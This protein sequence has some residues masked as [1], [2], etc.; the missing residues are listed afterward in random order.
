MKAKFLKMAKCKNGAELMKKYPTEEAFFAAFPE[1]LKMVKAQNGTRVDT[2]GNGIPDEYESIGSSPINGQPSGQFSLGN[3]P[4]APQNIPNS[5]GYAQTQPFANQPN[6]PMPT[7]ASDMFMKN[8]AQTNQQFGVPEALPADIGFKSS[9]PEASNSFSDKIAPYIGSA[10]DIVKGIA[11]LSGQKK[12]K[13]RVRQARKVSDVQKWASNTR[14]EAPERRYDT[15]WDRMVE[16][17]ERFPTYGVGSNVLTRNGGNIP[18]AQ[19][20]FSQI[21]NN[22]KFG[23]FMQEQGV[24][25]AFGSIQGALSNNSAEGQIGKGLGTAAGTVFG[26]PVGG[27]IGGMAGELIGG[28]FNTSQG[29]IKRDK[30]AI[31]RNQD[32]IMGNAMGMGIQNQYNA[33][34]KDGGDIPGYAMGGEIQTNEHGDIEE[35]AYNPITASNGGSGILGITKAAS[36]AK[37]DSTGKL[38]IGNYNGSEFNFEGNETIVETGDGGNLNMQETPQTKAEILGNLYLG[39][40]AKEAFADI[41]ENILKKI[42]KGRNIE[43]MKFKQLGNNIATV[44]KKVN[45]LNKYI[46]EFGANPNPTKLEESTA[47][48]KKIAQDMYYP[49]LDKAMNTAAALQSAYNDAAKEFGYKDSAKFLKDL[50]KGKIKTPS[51]QSPQAIQEYA[52]YG[53]SIASAKDG[54][55]TTTETTVD[56]K[57]ITQ[58]E[59]KRLLATGNWKVDPSDPNRIYE[60]TTK[61]TATTDNKKSATA[62]DNI[63]KQ[64]KDAKTGLYGGITPE[65]FEAYKKK[66]AW[67]PNWASFDPNDPK[68]VNEY[69]IAF[70]SESEKR[71][72]KARILADK[73][74]PGKTTLVGKQVTS[75]FLDDVA[76]ETPGTTASDYRIAREEDKRYETVPYKRSWVMD[77]ANQIL[78]FIRPSDQEGLDSNQ[79]MGEMYA[80]TN[81]QL[82]PVQAQ[83]YQPELDTPYDISFQDQL[84][85]NQSDFNSIQR[86]SAY[87]PAALSNLSAQKYAANS[88]V[89]GEQFRQNQ[90]ERSRVFGNNRNTLNDAQLKNISMYDQQYQRQSEAKSNTRAITQ[91][92]LNSIGSKYQQNK[93]ENRQLGIMENMY[94]YRFD[95]QGRAINMNPL[96]QFNYPTMYGKQTN[97]NMLPVY[98]AEGNQSGWKPAAATPGIVADGSRATAALEPNYVQSAPL[99][100]NGTS[101]GKSIAKMAK[102]GSIVKAYKNI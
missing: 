37:Q 68:D 63:P 3:S 8:S 73:Q 58:A 50:D 22:G 32:T 18:K 48:A 14:E 69:A 79:L 97:P 62:M 38:A 16:P 56:P 25:Q 87:N 70:N 74:T 60:V 20:G 65:Q 35:I 61:T 23:Q 7:T 55:T 29:S 52:E 11:G 66:N 41:N 71:G 81:N 34:V 27:M 83:S 88:Q 82:E 24:G 31:K 67:Y 30:R 100:K 59:K 78:P 19:S 102:N 94:N 75:A 42:T 1:A 90:G 9:M 91:A 26:G 15:P 47:H 92:A 84:N 43:K 57:E 86:T 80:L 5:V 44:T 40:P 51:L 101:I 46:E 53:T 93:L 96:A 4:F 64:S 2:N 6:F 28:A 89:L 98:D 36:H 21:L 85:A 77:V 33:Y 54:V 45:G 13:D 12:E 39:A 10:T 76:K 49:V 72:S 95:S 99:S 17:N